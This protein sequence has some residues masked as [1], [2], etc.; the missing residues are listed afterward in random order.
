[1]ELAE[2]EIESD[3]DLDSDSDLESG[4]EQNR[5]GIILLESKSPRL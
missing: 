3:L 4:P 2:E 5:G 1:M